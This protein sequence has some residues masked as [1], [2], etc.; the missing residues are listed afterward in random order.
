VS[1]LRRQILDAS[2][3]LVAEHGVRGVSFREVARRAN[4]SHQAPYHH[5]GDHRGILRELA[6]EGFV[7]LVRAMREQS[8]RGETPLDRLM[9]T[10]HAYVSFAR[11]HPG[12]FRI[13]FSDLAASDDQPLAEGAAAYATLVHFARETVA[14]GYGRG[15]DTDALAAVCWSTVHGLATLAVEGHLKRGPDCS[16]AVVEDSLRA[17]LEGLGVLCARE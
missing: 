15:L 10:G 7:E 6:R 4:V 14:D 2:A 13:M 9:A 12:H 5:F 8:E 1:D 16:P 11:T 3:A 17:V